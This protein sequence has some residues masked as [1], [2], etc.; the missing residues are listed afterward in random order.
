MTFLNTGPRCRA[1]SALSSAS[2]VMYVATFHPESPQLTYS[3]APECIWC[4]KGRGKRLLGVE[5]LAPSC[6]IGVHGSRAAQ[7]LNKSRLGNSRGKHKD[8]W[9][10]TWQTAEPKESPVGCPMLELLRSSFAVSIIRAHA[11]E[12]SDSVTT[13]QP[14]PAEILMEAAPIGVTALPGGAAKGNTVMESH[15]RY[16]VATWFLSQHLQLLDLQ[17]ESDV[18]GPG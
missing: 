4:T 13:G 7:N 17:G 8:I 10:G 3:Y 11:A 12:F 6:I 1:I 18:M 15:H 9:K 14:S 2:F 16:K 5:L